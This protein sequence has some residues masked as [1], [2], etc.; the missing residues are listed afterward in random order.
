MTNAH[1]EQYEPGG[2]IHVSRG[3]KYRDVI[4]KLIPQCSWV[5][6]TLYYTLGLPTAFSTDDR[7]TADVGHRAG[8]RKCLEG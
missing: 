7:L 8:V 3:V 6:Y 2:N 5:T 1:L 4:S